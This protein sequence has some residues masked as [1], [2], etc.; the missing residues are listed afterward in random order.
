MSAREVFETCCEG[1]QDALRKGTLSPN[2][3]KVELA[4]HDYS[5]AGEA[6]TIQNLDAAA[7]EPLGSAT[8]AD[9]FG[10]T[11]SVWSAASRVVPTMS[12]YETPIRMAVAPSVMS[13]GL[14]PLT[15]TCPRSNIQYSR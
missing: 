6:G 4:A 5:V 1:I 15:T 9:L 12:F 11:T 8:V 10:S 13:G 7:Y 3:S 14:G 2:A